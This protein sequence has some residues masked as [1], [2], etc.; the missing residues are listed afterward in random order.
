MSEIF[1]AL[2]SHNYWHG[3]SIRTGIT[4]QTYLDQVAAFSGNR[5][6]KVLVGQR[7]TGKSTILRQFIRNLLD[8]PSIAQNR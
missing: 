7:R 4:R 1:E 3:E 2:A 8:P 6:I 5:L